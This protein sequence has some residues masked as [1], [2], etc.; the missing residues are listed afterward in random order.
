MNMYERIKVECGKKGISVSA[1]ESELGFPRSS[2]CKWDKNIPSIL[3]V[4][5]VADR[6]GITLDELVSVSTNT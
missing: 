1:L 4:K 6:L 2:I 3:K 5:Q